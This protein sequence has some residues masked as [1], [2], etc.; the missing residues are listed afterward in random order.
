MRLRVI[1]AFVLLLGV[2]TCAVA[3]EP[4]GTVFLHQH[5]RSKATEAVEDTLRK[6]GVELLKS[7]NFNTAAHPGILNRCCAACD[8]SSLTPI[9]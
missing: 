7:S 2:A 9:F 5:G 8:E 3:G 4:T 6:L 1:P